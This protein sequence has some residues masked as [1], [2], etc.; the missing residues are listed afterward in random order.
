[1]RSAGLSGEREGALAGLSGE[2]GD[3]Q[4]TTSYTF[5]SMKY[6]L[7]FVAT[8]ILDVI[9][10]AILEHG[11]GVRDETIR[12]LLS[13]PFSMVLAFFTLKIILRWRANP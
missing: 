10:L 6:I 11:F 7:V 5:T 4:E 3:K 9:F 2:V 13:L 8:V 1:V 12:F